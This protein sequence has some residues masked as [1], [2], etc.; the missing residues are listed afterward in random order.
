MNSKKN[1]VE[2]IRGLIILLL[3]ILILLV[4]GIVFILNNPVDKNLKYI[5]SDKE[6][7][8]SVAMPLN[9]NKGF[10]DYR[11]FINRNYIYKA[12]DLFAKEQLPKY[13]HDVKKLDDEGIKKYFNKN[14]KRIKIELGLE[15]EEDFLELAKTIQ[16]IKNDKFEFIQYTINPMSVRTTN[17]GI[18]FAL[19]FE[20]K[21]Q[22]KIAFKI[23]VGNVAD[24]SKTPIRI[25]GGVD[26]KYL[27]YEYS[28][29]VEDYKNVSEMIPGGAP[30]KVVK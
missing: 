21:D 6:M 3:V 27:D 5:Y 18:S 26:P 11:G 24:E 8:I 29:T 7:K 20:Y 17:N 23:S 10:K 12:L 19:I 30:G 9:I 4:I 14:A 16:T 2:K 15:K 22:D 13:Y 25:R 1:K 28:S